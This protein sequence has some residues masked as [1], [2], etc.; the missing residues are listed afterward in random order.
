MNRR[1]FAAGV[2]LS[3]IAAFCG[4]QS[5]AAQSQMHGVID[6]LITHDGKRDELISILLKGTKDLPGCLSYVV[7][8]DLE[9]ANALWV[10][11]VWESRQKSEESFLLESVQEI[12]AKGKPLIASFGERVETQP[13]G[14]VGLD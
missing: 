9:D 12:M 3:A 11:E 4:S 2:G 1:D 14:R 8:K 5:L 6:K 10:T 13:V 7:S